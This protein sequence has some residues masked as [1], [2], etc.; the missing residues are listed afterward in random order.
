MQQAASIDE[1]LVIKVRTIGSLRLETS[2]RQLSFN[3][4]KVAALFVCLLMAGDVPQS[5][6]RLCGI[7]WPNSSEEK[8][9]SSLRQCI[10]QLGKSLREVEICDLF[11]VTKL[12]VSLDH[13]YLHVDIIQAENAIKTGVVP[14]VLLST[15]DLSE[16]W[17]PELRGISP[18]FDSW[19]AIS[20]N[21]MVERFAVALRACLKDASAE[22]GDQSVFEVA[23]ALIALDRTDEWACRS[24][25]KWYTL[26]GQSNQALRVYGRLWQQLD[27]EFDCEP[28]LATQQLAAEIKMSG[29]D[30]QATANSS[31]VTETQLDSFSKLPRIGVREFEIP[32]FVGDQQLLVAAFRQGLMGAMARFREWAII[33]ISRTTNNGLR[34]PGAMRSCTSHEISG[35][36]SQSCETRVLT[37]ALHETSSA[38]LLWSESLNFDEDS[39]FKFQEKLLTRVCAATNI[40]LTQARLKSASQSNSGD[41]YGAWLRGQSLILNWRPETERLAEDTFHSLLGASPDYAPAYASLASI[42]N[43][44]HL[45]FPGSGD[46]AEFSPQAL[47][48][49]SI[50]V[51]IDPIDTR[52]QLCLAWSHLMS[53]DFR[54]ANHHFELALDLNK[55]NEFTLVSCGH[56]FAFCGKVTEAVSCIGD[57]LELNPHMPAAHWAYIAGTR[58]LISDYEGCLAA[59]DCAADSILDMPAWE[60]AAAASLGE[61]ERANNAMQR[62]MSNVERHWCGPAQP[63]VGDV[64]GWFLGNLPIKD[65]KTA[66][67]LQDN[68]VLAGL[69]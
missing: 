24:L 56:G 30:Y 43:S 2:E 39:F 23:S 3:R 69:G 49:A 17:L 60:A 4:R 59:S 66:S 68:L 44:R 63:R 46:S 22:Q 29:T 5:R 64:A 55:N 65:P 13:R 9:R 27:E 11:Q 40:Y 19:L 51:E 20:R 47:K 53:R 54:Q 57:A 1:Q 50:A 67:R 7:L 58:Y 52:S 25:M 45:V 41:A 35:I 26:N 33:D 16:S 6:D 37:I 48:Y 28:E 36:V 10:L 15:D 34:E 21:N 14:K 32:N 31:S 42:Y 61:V 38:R 18:T 8:A 12:D 62:L